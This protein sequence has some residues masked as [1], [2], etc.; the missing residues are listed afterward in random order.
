M[1]QL[2]RLNA[3]TEGLGRIAAFQHRPGTAKVRPKRKVPLALFAIALEAR[4]I[5]CI[6]S[7]SSATLPEHLGQTRRGAA[8]V[9]TSQPRNRLAPNW[10]TFGVI[11]SQPAPSQVPAFPSSTAG[12]QR[13]LR[14]SLCDA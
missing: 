4:R 14:R 7:M 8:R 11:Q 2:S 10:M 13:R 1:I 3:W 5:F 6:R 12:Y 9:A